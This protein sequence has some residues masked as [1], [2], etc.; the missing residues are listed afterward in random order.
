M[1]ASAELLIS[2]ESSAVH[3]AAATNT[4]TICI[5]N[6]NTYKRFTPYPENIA[7]QIKTI[8]PKEIISMSEEERISSFRYNSNINNVTVE[9]V[10][11]EVLK[12]LNI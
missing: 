1:V 5:S 2:N 6:A 8:F 12:K 11:D 4:K 9:Q 3:V 7:P 10:Y